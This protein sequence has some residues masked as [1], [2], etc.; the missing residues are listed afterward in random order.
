MTPDT[1][2]ILLTSDSRKPCSTLLL[3][4][5]VGQAQQRLLRVCWVYL[6][7]FFAS[8]AGEQRKERIRAHYTPPNQLLLRGGNS[9]VHAMGCPERIQDIVTEEKLILLLKDRLVGQS[10]F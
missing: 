3:G 5:R 6:L 4:R 10:L 7:V 8:K 1:A 2:F 9:A